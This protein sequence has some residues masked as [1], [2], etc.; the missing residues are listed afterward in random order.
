MRHMQTET[1]NILIG[2]LFN[3]LKHSDTNEQNRIQW[4]FRHF[5]SDMIIF[6]QT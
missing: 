6:G 1:H 3:L 5:Q 2:L 4:D